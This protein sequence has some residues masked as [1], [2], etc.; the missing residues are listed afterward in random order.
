M[1]LQYRS[2]GSNWQLFVIDIHTALHTKA[3]PNPGP[4]SNLPDRAVWSWP[5]VTSVTTCTRS[6]LQ[7]DQEGKPHCLHLLYTLPSQ[8]TVGLAFAG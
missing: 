1:K 5:F 2:P 7:E 6:A 4:T 8:H 3:N